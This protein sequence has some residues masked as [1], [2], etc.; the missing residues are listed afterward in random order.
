MI[1]LG[2]IIYWGLTPWEGL[3]Q[4]PQH[5]AREL[6]QSFQVLYI[7]PLP[8]SDRLRRS[9][10]PSP[11]AVT[12]L[13]QQLTLLRPLALSPGR[14][15]PLARLNDRLATRLIT[16]H[17]QPGLPTILWLSH[18]DQ[19]G[20]I[21]RHLERLV[22]FDLMDAHAAFKR[23]AAQA[24]MA[25]A[26]LSILRRADLI[27]ASSQAL[28]ARAK[29]TGRPSILVPNAGEFDH[30]AQA[31]SRS[32]PEPLDL[33]AL[34]RPRLLFYGTL[35]EW[36]DT[37][38]LAELARA[39]PSWSII[40]LGHE[41]G[42]NWRPVIG[43]QNVYRLGRRP[44]TTLPAYLQHCDLCLLPFRGGELARAVDPVKL[45][46]YLAAGRPV[47]ATP[48]PELD[49]CGDLVDLASSSDQAIARI[50][51]HLHA[52]ESAERRQQ[53]V[54]FAAAQTWSARA[55]QVVAAL[56]TALAAADQ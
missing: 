38:L 54:Q 31:A 21:G 1:A 20:Q 34:P 52:P 15:S 56:T 22:C 2:Q 40:V 36:L 51:H 13:A 9:G 50:E 39:R 35:G 32:L 11:P 33:I 45:Y 12:R 47:V 55:H 23:G 7:D 37:H 3:L 53:R 14:L 43:L 6:S 16:A 42:A 8:L 49:K 18:P 25:A 24:A 17:R 48:L 28:L 4:R 46:E 44:Y 10:W 5:L 30:F 27:L 29:A 19:A 26:E 41:A